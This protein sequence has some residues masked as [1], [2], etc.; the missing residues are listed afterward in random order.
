MSTAPKIQSPES[1]GVWRR[2]LAGDAHV[3]V[4]T[5]TFDILQPGNLLAIRKAREIS[6]H[7]VVVV[8]PDP[9][10]ARHASA[11]R[12]QNNLETRVEM[13][14]CLRD[15]AAVTCV[16]P[17]GERALLA[18]LGQYVW[19]VAKTQRDQDPHSEMLSAAADCVDAIEPLPGCFTQDI[20]KSVEGKQTPISLPPGWDAGPL[21]QSSFPGGK[22]VRVTVNGCFDILHVGHLRF[23]AAARAMGDSLVVLTNND[24]SVAR[25]KGPT[26]PIFPEGFR[27]LA[28]KSLMSVDEVIAFPGDDPLDEIRQLRPAIHVKGGSYEPDR[29]RQERELVESW[30]GRLECTPMVEGFSTTNYIRRALQSG[31]N[32]K[33]QNVQ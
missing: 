3:A 9:V 19:V 8:E 11:G 12:P 18:S 15:V 24:L 5:G 28:L 33:Q 6:P 21:R 10:V 23:L 25:Y 20:I 13:V 2:Q 17:G 26:R 1:L 16:E 32:G 29:V 27:L 7:V 30:G 14:S 22:G 31:G 4:V